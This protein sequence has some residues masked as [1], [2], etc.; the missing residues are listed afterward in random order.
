MHDR[1]TFSPV[2]HIVNVFLILFVV[3]S[4]FSALFLTS[5]AG[6]KTEITLT[7]NSNTVNTTATTEKKSDTNLDAAGA[8]VSNGEVTGK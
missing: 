2:N 4:L 1:K 8:G 5:C 7:G 3:S 6:N